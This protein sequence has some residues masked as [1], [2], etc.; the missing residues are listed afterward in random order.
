MMK[1]SGEIRVFNAEAVAYNTG[2]D[3]VAYQGI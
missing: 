3:L 1:F 2:R